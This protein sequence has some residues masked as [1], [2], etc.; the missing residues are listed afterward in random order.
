MAYSKTVRR[1]GIFDHLLVSLSLRELCSYESLQLFCR[2]TGSVVCLPCCDSC[3][4]KSRQRPTS[5][6][7]CRS[8]YHIQLRERS[9]G[10]PE[11]VLLLLLSRT[12]QLLVRYNSSDM[13]DGARLRSTT[14]SHTYLAYTNL[15]RSRTDG[16]DKKAN[17]HN[18]G[19][20]HKPF[21]NNYR[22]N[23]STD[24]VSPSHQTADEYPPAN[25][26]EGGSGASLVGHDKAYRVQGARMK[27]MWTKMRKGNQDQGW[28]EVY[29][30]DPTGR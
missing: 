6:H 13:R 25:S 26:K 3:A 20:R 18:S 28:V 12:V 29:N 21:V 22:S 30:W 11:Y 2:P 15:I 16:G 7:R 10:L 5:R 23:F 14:P 19:Y 9:Y 27:D 4:P 8:S 1:S 24:A 17:R